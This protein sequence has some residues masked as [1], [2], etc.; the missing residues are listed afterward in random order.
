MRTQPICTCSI[1]NCTSRDK[2]SIFEL[3]WLGGHHRVSHCKIINKYEMLDFDSHQW[4]LDVCLVFKV[5]NGQTDLFTMT[6]LHQDVPGE[7]LSAE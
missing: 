6:G 2:E 3:N 7:R 1:L 5:V 4:F